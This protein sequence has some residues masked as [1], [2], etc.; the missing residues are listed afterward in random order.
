M[1]YF[2][3]KLAF[4]TGG[5]S[6][7]GLAA[8]TLLASKGCAL[9]LFARGRANL[10]AA[11]L[12]I[13]NSITGAQPI[14]VIPMDVADHADVGQK[15]DRAVA[16]FGIPDILVNSAG[17]GAGDYFD[18]ITYETFDRVMKIN[19]YGTRNT[20]SAVLPHMKKKGGGHIVN[21]ASMAGLIGMPGYSLYGST[22]YA[23]VGLSECLRGELKPFH[24]G[25][26]VVCPPEVTT[27]LVEAEA[28]TLPPESR[29]IKNMAGRLT[30]D[31]VA[32]ALVSGL[33]AKRFLVIPGRA[34]RM[35]H[36]FHR[37]SNGRLSRATADGI[38]G[39]VRARAAKKKKG[40]PS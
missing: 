31:E 4:I 38:G 37:I 8:A 32:L 40:R 12:A 28:K 15:I 35:L 3:D 2:N 18:N 6:G 19:V 14:H 7:I 33:R 25:V 5:S 39:F 27:P 17:V 23:L 29:M 1:R 9:V 34:A 26:T 20:I 10:E 30:P 16:S 36:F 21:L 24:I 13:R 11:R 22:K